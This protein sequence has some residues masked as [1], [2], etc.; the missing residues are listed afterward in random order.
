M[1]LRLRRVLFS[2]ASACLPRIGI[3]VSST[4]CCSL[5]WAGPAP[6]SA[7]RWPARSCSL[8]R[9][10]RAARCSPGSPASLRPRPDCPRSC[11]E[12]APSSR[13]NSAGVRPSARC[14][15]SEPAAGPQSAPAS[16][17][18]PG[19]RRSR[20]RCHFIPSARFIPSER[21]SSWAAS[22]IDFRIMVKLGSHRDSLTRLQQL[23]AASRRCP[24]FPAAASRST[25]S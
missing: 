2:A 17:P 1:L 13:R 16:V 6:G 22:T 4:C 11:D 21:A 3:A 12:T 24:W 5:G 20:E 14:S 23:L 7:S 10:A 18:A 15:P 25:H 8:D 19:A 9:Q